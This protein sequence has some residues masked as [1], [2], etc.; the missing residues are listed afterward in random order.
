MTSLPVFTLEIF[1]LSGYTVSS[2]RKWNAFILNVA[3]ATLSCKNTCLL[4]NIRINVMYA[5]KTC[6]RLSDVDGTKGRNQ[7]N[8][9]N[10]FQMFAPVMCTL[11][12]V[13]VQDQGWVH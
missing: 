12:G 10:V 8:K 3:L 7:I 9:K 13:L 11:L 6:A 2:K 5:V 1:S 4:T